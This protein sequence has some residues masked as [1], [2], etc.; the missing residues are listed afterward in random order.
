MSWNINQDKKQFNL[1]DKIKRNITI[2]DKTDI[3][4]IKTKTHSFITKPFSQKKKDPYFIQTFKDINK[5]KCKIDTIPPYQPCNDNSRETMRNKTARL[6]ISFYSKGLN[7]YS[8][9][10]FLIHLSS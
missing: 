3:L 7:D 2:G 9:L 6:M 1:Y 8:W 5:K 10:L 4:N